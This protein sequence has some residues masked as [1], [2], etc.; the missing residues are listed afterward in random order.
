MK[1]RP[2][3][4]LRD[5]KATTLVEFSLIAPL[6]FLLTFGIVDFA[7][8]FYQ[9]QALNV[10]TGIAARMAA[11]RGPVITG[12]PDCGVGVTATAG[13]YCGTI[14]ASK[15]WTPRT[16][17]G[18]AGAPTPALSGSTCNTT[19]MTRIVTEMQRVYPPLALANLSVTYGPSGL[20]FQGLGK[21][22]PTVTVSISG[23]T[24]NFIVLSAFGIGNVTLP[25]FTTTIVAEDL[26]GA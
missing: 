13:Q 8:I 11:T 6:L 7:A 2:G 23:V 1:R 10:A 24:A 12:I 17:T 4:F 26:S 22:V 14:A 18:S 20:G 16:C 9:F 15:T 3:S 25:P 5:K 19:L 21:P